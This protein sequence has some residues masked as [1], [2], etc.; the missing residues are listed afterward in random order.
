MSKRSGIGTDSAMRSLSLHETDVLRYGSLALGVAIWT[1]SMAHPPH[2]HMYR[3]GGSNKAD[4]C[5]HRCLMPF[6]STG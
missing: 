1:T 5:R 4:G 2:A 6:F 3:T